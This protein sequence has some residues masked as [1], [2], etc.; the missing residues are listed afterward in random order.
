MKSR[1]GHGRDR[2]PSIFEDPSMY[3]ESAPFQATDLLG[4]RTRLK[5]ELKPKKKE[6]PPPKEESDEWIYS[7]EEEEE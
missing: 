7:G 1:I 6:K 5:D 4:A 3:E 2:Q